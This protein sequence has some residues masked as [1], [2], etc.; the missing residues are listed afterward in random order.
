MDVRRDERL[1]AEVMK[2]LCE[3][4][5]RAW[6]ERRFECE[7]WESDWGSVV[8]RDARESVERRLRYFADVESV[9]GGRG[10]ELASAESKYGTSSSK[11]G[12]AMMSTH[13]SHELVQLCLH[14]RGCLVHYGD[15]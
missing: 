8:V 9:A 5:E 12:S 13:R 6:R 7:A 4:F 14:R 1:S 10:G 3:R 2:A 15:S 11:R